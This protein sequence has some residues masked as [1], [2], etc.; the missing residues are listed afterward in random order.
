VVNGRRQRVLG[1]RRSA[2]RVSLTGRARGVYRI[3]LVIRTRRGRNVV[4]PRTY[5]TCTRRGA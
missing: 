2:V 4:D 1:G 5:R 3:R